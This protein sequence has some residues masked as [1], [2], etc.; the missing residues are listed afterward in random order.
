MEGN[1]QIQN[2]KMQGI[3]TLIVD[4]SEQAREMMRSQLRI[5]G[6]SH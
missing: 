6:A 2:G 4:D 3:K 1:N 5:F